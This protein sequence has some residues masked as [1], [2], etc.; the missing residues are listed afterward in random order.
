MT[1]DTHSLIDKSKTSFEEESKRF[2]NDYF[3]MFVEAKENNEKKQEESDDEY[4]ED[5]DE[6][7]EEISNVRDSFIF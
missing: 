2:N 7:E 1:Y 5:F 3:K 4:E 6:I